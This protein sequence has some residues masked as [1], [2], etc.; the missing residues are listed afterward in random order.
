[1]EIQRKL[2]QVIVNQLDKQK[3]SLLLG[4]R[5]VGKT[6]LLQAIKAQYGVQ[7][8]WL[9]G[10][11]E[12]VAAILNERTVANYSRLLQGY[13][14]LIIDEAQFIPDIGRKLKLM[15]DEIAPLHIIITG[16]SAFDIGQ[17]GEPLVGR[18]LTYQM[19]PIAQCE[20]D[21][22]ENPLQT[23]QYLEERLLFGSYPEVLNLPNLA[24]KQQYLAELVNTYLLK[25]I[26]AF[27]NIRNPQKLKDLLVLLAW[28]IGSEVS[29]DELGR[30][31]GL[32]KNTVHRYLDLL[33]KVFVL[34][35]RSGYSKNLRKE[36]AKS[37]RWYFFDTGIRNALINNFNFLALRQDTGMLWENYFITERQ[38][39]NS[40]DGRL[41]NSYFWR[42]YDQQEIDLLEVQNDALTAFECKWSAQKTKPPVAFAKAYPQ[43]QFEVVH[44]E[45]YL[46]FVV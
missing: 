1:M 34:Y 3:V 46:S 31:L 15:I 9:N 6:S 26:L 5:R 19:Y 18:T 36:V 16:S 21:A 12:N 23:R 2:L 27:E 14:L 11:D 38:K 41:V 20:L 25:D 43:A 29:L 22:Q 10:E 42:T 33:E 8:L 45:H 30:N 7:C 28:Q 39:K 37:N 35:K 24:Q 13:T 17:I 40:Y 44:R 32:N 4:A